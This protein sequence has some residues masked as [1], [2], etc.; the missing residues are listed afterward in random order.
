MMKKK[1]VISLCICI[2]CACF[3]VGVLI[4]LLVFV[5]PI[6]NI[7]IQKTIIESRSSNRDFFVQFAIAIGT[8]GA[9]VITLVLQLKEKF[10]APKL[11][12]SIKK[13]TPWYNK[14]SDNNGN[15]RKHFY[16]FIVE[17]TKQITA[18]DVKIQ[19]LKVKNLKTNNY[20]QIYPMLFNWAY[21]GGLSQNIPYGYKSFC[22]FI[23]ITEECNEIDKSKMYY[24]YFSKLYFFTSDKI[25]KGTL[26][27]NSLNNGD[28][29][30]YFRVTGANIKP[31]CYSIQISLSFEIESKLFDYKT[32]PNSD[33]LNSLSEHSRIFNELNKNEYLTI[34]NLKKEKL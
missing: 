20:E 32:N 5:R 8:V 33:V 18:Q 21:D 17:N 19:L 15:V 25:Q 16:R 10:Q 7:E 24:F 31:A 1:I 26:V 4:A 11:K 12:I 23:Y 2:G 34:S 30:V 13:E 29:L 27:N 14:E 9:V 3:V 6:D 28:Y 22:D